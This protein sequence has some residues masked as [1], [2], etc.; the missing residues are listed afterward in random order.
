MACLLKTVWQDVMD[1]ASK[2]LVT[3]ELI[4][5]RTA[6]TRLAIGGKGAGMNEPYQKQNGVAGGIFIAIGL[7]GGA[8]I[9]TLKGQSSIGMVAGLGLGI[10]AAVL[11]WLYDRARRS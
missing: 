11:V 2:R 7:L 3:A 10:L 5:S 4:Q 1:E 6:C 8:I 9:G